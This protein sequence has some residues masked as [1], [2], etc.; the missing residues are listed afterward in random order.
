MRVFGAEAGGRMGGVG[1]IA[2]KN[3][4]DWLRDVFFMWLK[5]YAI[6]S[7]VPSFISLSSSL[8]RREVFF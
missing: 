6:S 2:Q 8:R 7:G 1:G 5:D 3:V 4:P